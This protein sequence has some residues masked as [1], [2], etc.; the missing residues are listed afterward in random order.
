VIH[1]FRQCIKWK[2]VCDRKA[3]VR[4]ECLSTCFIHSIHDSA[5]LQAQNK[6][7][8]P[9]HISNII[10]L[11]VCP[12]PAL[13]LQFVNLESKTRMQRR[14]H[15]SRHRKQISKGWKPHRFS[16]CKRN[17]VT[18]HKSYVRH[19]YIF[20]FYKW[21]SLTYTKPVVLDCWVATQKQ[22]IDLFL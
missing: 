19:N 7:N 13:R 2:W 9:T 15:G 21:M 14:P 4:K 3:S 17:V 11:H 20:V 1:H 16:C 22:A 5:C 10:I 8:T 6:E 18:S 12:F